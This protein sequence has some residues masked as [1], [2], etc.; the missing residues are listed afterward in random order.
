M[1]ILNYFFTV[2]ILLLANTVMGQYFVNYTLASA[3]KVSINVY[4]AQ[5]KIV[6]VLLNAAQRN[7]GAN[8]ETWDG[9]DQFGNIAPVGNYTWKLLQ[10][11]GFSAKYLT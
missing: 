10:T 4:D 11:Q 2:C 7:A 1:K 8:T 5:G 6:Q 9:K 3:G